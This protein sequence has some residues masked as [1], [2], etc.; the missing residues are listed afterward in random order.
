M[1]ARR[2]IRKVIDPSL[3]SHGSLCV[4]LSSLTFSEDTGKEQNI[5]IAFSPAC[6]THPL[7][8]YYPKLQDVRSACFPLVSFALAG[9]GVVVVV[10]VEES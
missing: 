3:E 4:I 6:E 8:S 1:S 7:P 2:L 5:T 10:V 9:R